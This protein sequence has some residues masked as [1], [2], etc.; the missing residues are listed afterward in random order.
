MNLSTDNTTWINLGKTEQSD[1]PST[2]KTQI[3]L[4]YSQDIF[5]GKNAKRIAVLMCFN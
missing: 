2:S 5:K 4:N 1:F 3:V